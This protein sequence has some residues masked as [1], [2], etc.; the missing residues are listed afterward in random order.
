MYQKLTGLYGQ[1]ETVFTNE[2]SC[3]SGNLQSM[4][5]ETIATRCSKKSASK[6]KLYE[7]QLVHAFQKVISI[8]SIRFP[9]HRDIFK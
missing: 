9:L 1:S 8:L 2:K 6:G 7:P 3:S 4:K 5:L